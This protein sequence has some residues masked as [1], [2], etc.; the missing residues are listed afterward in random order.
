MKKVLSGF[1]LIILL[2]LIWYLFIKSYDYTVRFEANTSP[3]AINQTL[4]LW[5]RTLD[6]IESIEQKGSLYHLMQ[7][8]QFNDSVHLYHWKIKSLTDSTSKVLVNIKDVDYSFINKVKVPFSDTDFEKRSRKT[9]LEFMEYLNEHIDE[10]KVTIIGEEEMPSKYVA[11]LPI[12]ATQ[13][14]KA[15]EMMKNT[16]YLS[17]TLLHS[18]TILDGPPMVEITKW[19]RKNDSLEYNF[20]YPIIRSDH[21]PINT[22]I[23]YKR[24]FG[25]KALKAIYN[26]NYITSDRAWYALLDYAKTKGIQVE[27]HPIE[28]FHNN[29]TGG[30]EIEWKAEIYLPIKE[31]LN[32]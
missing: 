23:E 11:Y 22:E 15:D 5:D 3:G 10:F 29:P 4:K 30:N 17:Q 21:L 26:G 1:L 8:V 14:K 2:G 6:T 7:K 20:C 31:S 16:S 19:D 28:I 24:I 18:K 25:K 13:F 12:K 32:E 27:P 9:V